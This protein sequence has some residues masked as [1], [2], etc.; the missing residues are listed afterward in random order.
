[1]SDKVIDRCHRLLDTIEVKS[2]DNC[3]GEISYVR[4]ALE[5]QRVSQERRDGASVILKDVWKN[6]RE[7]MLWRR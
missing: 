2:S 4:E 1:M 6:D 5:Q 7:K 3:H